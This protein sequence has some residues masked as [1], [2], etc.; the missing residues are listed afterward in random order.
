M[1]NSISGYKDLTTV[2]VS[3][4]NLNAF[5]GIYEPATNSTESTLLWGRVIDD[6]NDGD[7]IFYSVCFGPN[8]MVA[9]G[10]YVSGPVSTLT[11]DD[12]VD[13]GISL[14]LVQW[15]YKAIEDKLKEKNGYA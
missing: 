7:D 12:Y 3:N 6:V 14:S 4:A 10:G 8:D 1:A 13:M 9:V 2:S 15:Q 11:D 5:I